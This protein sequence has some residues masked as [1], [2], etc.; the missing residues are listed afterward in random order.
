MISISQRVPSA[1][2][3]GGYRLRVNP[4]PRI[5]GKTWHLLKPS[6]SAKQAGK[7]RAVPAGQAYCRFIGECV[8]GQLSHKGRICLQQSHSHSNFIGHFNVI[9]ATAFFPRRRESRKSN[10]AWRK[11]SLYTSRQADQTVRCT[12]VCDIESGASGRTSRTGRG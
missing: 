11:S 12:S 6:T 1:G 9:P 5:P 8:P 7:F 10:C 3:S 4:K 2:F